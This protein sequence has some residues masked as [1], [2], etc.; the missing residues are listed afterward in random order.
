MDLQFVVDAAKCSGCKAC[1]AECPRGII[2]FDTHVPELTSDSCLQCQHCL[3]VCP[4][5]AI[6]ILGFKPEDSI[7]LTANALPS[8]SQ[9][10]TFVR[11]RRSVRRF[12]R[13]NV[14]P[15]LIDEL[16][17]DTANAPTGCNDRELTF[18]VIDDMAIMQDLR[19][20]VVAA[21]EQKDKANVAMPQFLIDGVRNYKEH[22]VD[23]FFRNA[24][25]L[26]IISAGNKANC[27]HEDVIIALSYFELLAQSAGIGTTWCG[28]FKYVLDAVPELADV[29]GLDKDTSFCYAMMFGKPAVQYAR[30]V[31][32]D[33]TA[34]VR[35]VKGLV[36]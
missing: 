5:G 23:D 22:G 8:K 25:H 19:Q 14:A 15:A 13:E 7:P 20:R 30:T 21:V 27:G 18:T 31:Q 11:A 2:K 32:H 9:M 10:K 24:P 3:A 29:I 16:L 4:T 12:A 36:Q 17:R 28:Y 33:E 6:S 34:T 26:L 35:R 1:V